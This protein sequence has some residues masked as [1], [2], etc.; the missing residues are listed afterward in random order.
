MTGGRAAF[1]RGARLPLVA[2]LFVALLLFGVAL[3]TRP[4]SEPDDPEPL[5]SRFPTLVADPEPPGGPCLAVATHAR[6]FSFR[7]G[8]QALGRPWTVRGAFAARSGSVRLLRGSDG[9]KVGATVD[10]VL[11]AASIDTDNMLRDQHLR[12]PDLLAVEAHPSLR[13]HATDGTVERDHVDLVGEMELLSVKR[14]YGT[15]APEAEGPIRLVAAAGTGDLREALGKVPVRLTGR[16]T[17]RRSRFGLTVTET[18]TWDARALV[19]H[20]DD[21]VSVTVDVQIR[22]CGSPP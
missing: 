7:I 9:A 11:D 2:V 13:F 8:T 1:L 17:V 14:P 10:V 3:W 6:S 12:A 20:I 19:V 5:P 21:P 16:F 15:G 18:R 4:P 22:P